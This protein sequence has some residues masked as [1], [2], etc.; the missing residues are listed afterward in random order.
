[1]ADGPDQREL[2]TVRVR[3]QVSHKLMNTQGFL[4]VAQVWKLE[5]LFSPQLL[6]MAQKFPS[7]AL[8]VKHIELG[9]IKNFSVCN[10]Q[11]NILSTLRCTAVLTAS[12]LEDRLDAL[13]YYED[14]P[15]IP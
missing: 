4:A 9:R 10:F 1:M 11:A 7:L 15:P 14:D 6:S 2:A 13:P 5:S 8:Q 12:G 3:W